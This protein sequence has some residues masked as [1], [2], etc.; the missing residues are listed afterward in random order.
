MTEMENEPLT[1]FGITVKKFVVNFLKLIRKTKKTR[2]RAENYLNDVKDEEA[3]ARCP[4]LKVFKKDLEK[5]CSVPHRRIGTEH[6]HQIE[7]AMVETFQEIGLERVKKEPIEITLWST[8]NWK[9]YIKNLNDTLEI[10]CF[11][12][13]NTGFT[14]KDGITAPLVYVGTGRK[15]D[16][17]AIDVKGKIIVADIENPLLPV[18]K[19]LK[20]SKGYMI[21]DPTNSI[22]KD[23]DIVLTF[24]LMNFKP[25]PLGTELNYNT[26][27]GR[28]IENGALGIVFILKDYPSNINTHWGPYDGLMKPLPA[29][30]V[31]KYDGMKL[32]EIAQNGEVQAT[33]ILEGSK[34]PGIA[35]NILGF[36]PGKSDEIILISSHHDSAFQGASEDGTGVAG[37]LAQARAWAQVPK[38]N[39][40]RTLLFL[41]TAGHLYA[42]IGAET[43]AKTH[44]DDI[45]KDVLAN[46][47]LEHLC[48]KEVEEDPMNLG[49]RETGNLALGVVFLSNNV[50]IIAHTMKSFIQNKIERMVLVPENFFATPPIGEAG[51]LVTHAPNINVICFIRSPY[52]LLNS[53]DTLDKIDYNKIN[54]KNQCV[55]DI[56]NSLMTLPKEEFLKKKKP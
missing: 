50:P 14:P 2:K 53:E 37:V 48:A 47:N 25:Q 39:R 33:L 28:A 10:P 21:S 20:L 27:Y 35:H 43:F 29:L 54:S 11:Y 13:I 44:K 23:T 31:G 26:L 36:L 30:Y 55:I 15:K 17:K 1:D 3:R 51:H 46:I 52:Y 24:A 32:R 49:Y 22:D 7:D 45:I 4:D 38:E 9:L 18:G 5:I 41:L 6:A 56:V 40:P 12:V 8:T 42:G 34:Q 16:F 19:I